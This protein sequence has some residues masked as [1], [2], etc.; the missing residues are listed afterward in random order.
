[1]PHFSQWLARNINGLASAADDLDSHSAPTRP[2]PSTQSPD[3]LPVARGLRN[4]AS[5]GTNCARIFS[6]AAVAAFRPCF[7]VPTRLA[8]RWPLWLTQIDHASFHALSHTPMPAPPSAQRL[9]VERSIARSIPPVN[10]TSP[11]PRRRADR[12]R[13]LP[14]GRRPRSRRHTPSHGSGSPVQAIRGEATP[15]WCTEEHSPRDLDSLAYAH[16]ME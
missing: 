4:D 2:P 14:L 15:V 1:M 11:S 7:P 16:S 3:R 13:G 5:S 8:F 9:Q 6:A 12:P 10:P